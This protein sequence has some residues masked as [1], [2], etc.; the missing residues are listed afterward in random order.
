MGDTVRGKYV[1]PDLYIRIISCSESWKMKLFRTP[2]PAVKGI[3]GAG[4][5]VCSLRTNTATLENVVGPI[6]AN[7]NLSWS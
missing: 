6:C 1:F 7:Q 4:N 5:L 2:K 3:L